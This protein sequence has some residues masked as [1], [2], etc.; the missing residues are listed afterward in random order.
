MNELPR[1]D[2]PPRRELDDLTLARARTGDRRALDTLVRHYQ[3]PVYAVVGRM[4]V[5]RPRD[6]VDDVAQDTFVKVVGAIARFDPAGAAA[7]STWILTIATRTSI[8]YLRRPVRS[9][10]LDEV[11]P[12]AGEPSTEPSPEGS[13]AHRRL[14]ARVEAAMESLAPEYRAVLIL[15]AY[16]DLDYPEIAD[17]LGVATGTVKSRLSRARE[18]LRGAV[19]GF[20]D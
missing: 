4:L 16:N 10:P 1:P 3:G 13:A 11:G 5:G 2:V 20:D 8:D 9:V 6:C 19:G 14:R 7:L 17:V 12:E 18:A 15:R